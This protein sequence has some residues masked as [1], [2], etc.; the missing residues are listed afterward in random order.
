V[1]YVELRK[2]FEV[3]GILSDVYVSKNRNTCGQVY[4]FVRFT[5][6]LQKALNNVFIG[7][8]IVWANVARFD[9]F[10]EVK[11]ELLQ[12]QEEGR[13]S[14]E[15]GGK[16]KSK[17]NIDG[18]KITVRGK[19]NNEGADIDEGGRKEVENCKLP[20]AREQILEEVKLTTIGSEEE[21]VID[22]WQVHQILSK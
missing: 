6:K 21:R 5:A 4:G 9:R 11:K 2:A 13:K 10:G 20:L 8:N 1:H 18:E 22:V 3:C 15:D 19:N 17:N 12:E 14:V 16:N 7:Q